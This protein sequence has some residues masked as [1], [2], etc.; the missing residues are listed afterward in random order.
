MMAIRRSRGSGK[1][2][3]VPQQ[4]DDPVTD[5]EKYPMPKAKKTLGSNNTQAKK[6]GSQEAVM[7]AM[8]KHQKTSDGMGGM[9]K[10]KR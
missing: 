1:S 10:G 4:E 9:S 8:G 6:G 3:S 2:R 5:Y 7:G